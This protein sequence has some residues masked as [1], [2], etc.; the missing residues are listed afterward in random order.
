M[1]KKI[2][3]IQVTGKGKNLTLVPFYEFTPTD[4]EGEES[5]TRTK[6]TP[7]GLSL[8]L[9]TGMALL[10]FQNYFPGVSLNCS[11]KIV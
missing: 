4:N 2:T 11:P 6:P 1:K 9:K 7:S 10:A 8:D 5:K 3:H